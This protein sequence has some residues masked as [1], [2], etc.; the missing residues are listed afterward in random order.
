MVKLARRRPAAAGSVVELAARVR[1]GD[2][3]VVGGVRVEAGELHAVRGDQ[4]GAALAGVEVVGV[5]A[6]VD[7]RVGGLVRV[8]GDRRGAV[9]RDR[10]RR[11]WR[12][13]GAVSS[14][15]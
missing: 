7:P 5:G 15:A 11:R 2:P 3:V 10:M 1:R 13:T 9:A 8:P 12:S 6:V 4:R 14:T